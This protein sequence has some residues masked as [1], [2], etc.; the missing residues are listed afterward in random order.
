M[1]TQARVVIGAAGRQNRGLGGEL[2]PGRPYRERMS[3]TTPDPRA[4]GGDAPQGV[5]AG[6][7][8]VVT[9]TLVALV[10]IIAFETMATSTV[11]PR[12]AQALDVSTGYGLAFSFMFTTQLLG[13]V[14]AAPWIAR[15]GPMPAL[16]VG[17]ALFAGGSLVCG[18]APT[19]PLF[20]L[21][22]LIAGLG[23]GLIV[24]AIY[25]VI[26]AV[27]ADHLR[28]KVF[29]WISAAWVLPSIV[30][31]FLAG[32]ISE[33]W[34]WRAVFALVAPATVLTAWAL[35]RHRRPL[36]AS[37]TP[38][39]AE[40]TSGRRAMLLGVSVAV[41]GGLLQWA[42]TA[43]LP[44]RPAPLVAGAVGLLLLAVATPRLLPTGTL[45]SR[46]GLP[47]VLLARGLFTASFNGSVTFI[48]LLLVHQ[49]G[50]TLDG[51]GALL[52]L[53]SLGW[54]SGAWIQGR[55]TFLG[56]GERLLVAG[57]ACCTVGTT[58]YA[59]FAVL[60]WPVAALVAATLVAGLGMGLASSSSSVL[61]L[62]LAPRSKH[63][64]ASSSL[65]LCDVLG[66]MLGLA[67]TGALFATLAGG[68]AS[69]PGV[70]AAMWLL[71]AAI[72]ALALLAGSRATLPTPA[73][74]PAG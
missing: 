9:L 33:A 12:V 73:D 36:A 47:S 42:G 49:R 7:L 54:A 51:A 20:L 32:R 60:H 57:G 30:G 41:G 21:G 40:T 56:R 16:W 68:D 35:A 66:S 25:V 46:R 4:G 28:P 24:V 59:L 67:A 14:L 6:P 27:F 64:S 55:P 45:L 2:D 5:L 58:L 17:Q 50:L 48:P 69:Q 8:R 53:S 52:A 62:A 44:P 34:T 3:R 61:T 43:L 71:T 23:A 18:F 26:G 39:D 38:T 11:M 37:H 63:S 15:A 19:Y 65:Q 29:S 22:R 74:A 10:T 13:I 31:P 70:F 72:A 1:P